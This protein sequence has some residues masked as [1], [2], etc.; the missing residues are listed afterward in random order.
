LKIKTLLNAELKESV[1]RNRCSS[2]FCRKHEA[3]IKRHYSIGPLTSTQQLELWSFI[4]ARNLPGVQ[5]VGESEGLFVR[6]G[7]GTETKFFMDGN[8]VNN[9]FGN[10]VLIKALDRLNTSLFK[11]NV[12]QWWLFCLRTSFIWN[13]ALESIDLPERNSADF[14][15]SPIFAS[16]EFNE[17]IKKKHILTEFL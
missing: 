9:Y 10:S 14:G 7:T 11:G 12:F 4:G 3:A 13:L 8:L 16:G 17:L 2:H 15:I 1:K 6:G 5:K